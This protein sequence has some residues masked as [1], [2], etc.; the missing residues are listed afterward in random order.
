MDAKK[1]PTNAYVL[2]EGESYI[3]FTHGQS[4]TEF[5]FKAALAGIVLGVVFG[6]ANG[7]SS[8]SVGGH[9]GWRADRGFP[10]GHSQ[11][12]CAGARGGDHSGRLGIMVK[13]ATRS[14]VA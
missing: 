4:L 11:C 2:R 9:S 5:T 12:R 7:R 6:A 14:A 3:P 10:P 1:L 8:G 13:I